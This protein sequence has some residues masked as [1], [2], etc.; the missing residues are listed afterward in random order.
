MVRQRRWMLRKKGS[1]R[2][3]GKVEVVGKEV[4]KGES[5]RG[6]GKVEMVG[7]E[8]RVGKVEMVGKEVIQARQAAAR[9][10]QLQP[11]RGHPLL[12]IDEAKMR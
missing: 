11:R 12:L 5:V 1:V 7:R 10:G 8:V 2:G 9:G 4:K 6:V 3:V